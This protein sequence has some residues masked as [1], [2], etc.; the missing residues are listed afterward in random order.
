MFEAI[1]RLN[2]S[3]SAYV[4]FWVSTL[5]VGNFGELY[6]QWPIVLLLLPLPLGMLL[7]PAASTWRPALQVP[8]FDVLTSL[9]RSHTAI[10]RQRF[11]RAV[12]LLS[13]WSLL[14]VSA[15][16]PTWIGQ[17]VQLPVQGRD[18]MIAVDISGSMDIQDMPVG[19]KRI[20]RVKAVKDVVSSFIARRQGDRMGLILFGS[21]PYLQA[22][23]SFD[24]KTIGTLLAEAQLGFA[25][26]E[27]AL[28]DAV[29]L[30]VKRLRDRPA[31][32]RVLILLTD[33]RNNAGRFDPT[34]AAQLAALEGVRIYTIG[35]GAK[36]IPQ[37][38]FFGTR[39]IANQELDENTLRRIARL[40]KGRYFR[41][42]DPAEL[43][44]IYETLDQL[45]PI[46]LDQEVFR[47]QSTRFHY[48]LGTALLISLLWCL[49][50]TLIQP[51]LKRA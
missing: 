25:G 51:L 36:K 13:V 42:H 49:W 43:E 2:E 30:S 18:M 17:P 24:L 45:E 1:S 41:A 46:D 14:L 47:P 21:L 20:R 5:S 16:Q 37:R 9:T 31:N 15:A 8:F 23:L 34:Q 12:L 6:L 19:N 35:V 10:S 28:G 3:V 50:L 33:G 7:L 4:N 38:S 22:P 11:L 48:P 27:T 40:T 39:H 26:Q 29:A 44:K 32:S